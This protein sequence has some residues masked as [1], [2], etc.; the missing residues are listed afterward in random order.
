M[1]KDQA[2]PQGLPLLDK[3]LLDSQI[4]RQSAGLMAQD[5][6]HFPPRYRI[7]E[8]V[9]PRTAPFVSRDPLVSK[10]Q[11]FVYLI[12]LL[13][14]VGIQLGQ[15][16]VDGVLPS[17]TQTGDSSIQGYPHHG[18]TPPEVWKVTIDTLA[19]SVDSHRGWDKAAKL[20]FGKTSEAW[21]APPDYPL[22]PNHA[23]KN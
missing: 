14:G 13:V 17:L 9:Q 16:T 8:P 2:H 11:V 12:A 3:P 7:P 20:P 10:H 21:L 4:A 6:V 22:E 19:N 15:L 18:W 23:H 5:E 1:D